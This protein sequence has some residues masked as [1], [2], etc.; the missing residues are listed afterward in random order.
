M[1]AEETEAREPKGMTLNEKPDITLRV[2]CFEVFGGGTRL[3]MPKTIYTPE[4]LS[5]KPGSGA[6][7]G[8][9]D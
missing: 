1:E 4:S 9:L 3:A 2:R 8:V 6:T 7:E 5:L